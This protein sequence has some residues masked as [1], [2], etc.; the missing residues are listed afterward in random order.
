MTLRTSMQRAGKSV[1]RRSAVLLVSVLIVSGCTGSEQLIVVKAV[2]AGVPSLAPF[3]DEQKSGLGQDAQLRSER[4]RGSLQQGNTPGL[5]GGTR[6][7]RVCDV[8]RLKK[9]LTDPKNS[10]KALE[11]V[12]VIGISPEEIERYLDNLTPVLLRHDTLVVNHDYKKAKAVPFNALLEAGIAVLVNDQ[13]LPAVKCS[14]G[15]PLRPFDGDTRRI[16]VRFED[17][18]T[19]WAG[20]DERSVVAVQPAPRRLE[21]LALVDVDEPGRGL[22]RPVGTDGRQDRTFDARAERRVP[23]LS[24][25]TYASASQRLLGAG[26]AVGYTGDAPPPDDAAVVGS[27]PRAGT[28][29]RW[30]EYVTLSVNTEAQGTTPPPQDTD[31][32]GSASGGP[33]GGTGTDGPSGGTT[34]GTTGGSPSTG[35]SDS[36][37]PSSPGAADGA[38]SSPPGGPSDT[39]PPGSGTGGSPGGSPG[40]PTGGDSPASDGGSTTAGG[41][42]SEGSTTE[43]STTGGGS[44]PTDGGGTASGGGDAPSDRAGAGG[45]STGGGGP[46]SGGTPTGSAGSSPSRSV[47]TASAGPPTG[48]ARPSGTATVGGTPT[49]S[50]A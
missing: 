21:R 50:T 39:P 28:E 20:Y 16:S 15:N 2:A 4:P 41:S 27:R 31:S 23:D 5:Y 24:G 42:T 43:G 30:G 17:G 29:L 22:D 18:N 37:S 35:P 9:F 10:Q 1:L 38:S 26:L 13:G 49:Q 34:G 6:K 11:W 8:E 32:G 47:P 33:D 3:F 25:M 19:K 12:R 36:G 7:P 14:C 48:T 45:T 40:A 46:G 44:T